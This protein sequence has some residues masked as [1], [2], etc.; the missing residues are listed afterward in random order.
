MCVLYVCFG[1]SSFAVGGL[2]VSLRL[3]QGDDFGYISG[4]DVEKVAFV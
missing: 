1:G 4:V 3:T 2:S